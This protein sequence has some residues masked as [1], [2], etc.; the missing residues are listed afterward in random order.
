MR[1]G[2]VKA[3]P[4][5][6]HVPTQHLISVTAR[7]TLPRRATPPPP[8]TCRREGE[9]KW[10]LTS[11]Q[12]LHGSRCPAT[13]SRRRSGPSAATLG[14]RTRW[15]PAPLSCARVSGKGT[16]TTPRS[17]AIPCPHVRKSRPS[18]IGG[19]VGEGTRETLR[20]N[21]SAP[22]SRGAGEERG[23]V[24]CPRPDHTPPLFQ[25]SDLNLVGHGGAGRGTFQATGRKEDTQASRLHGLWRVAKFVSF[26][27]HARVERAA[28]GKR[29]TPHPWPRGHS[30]L[31]GGADGFS[32]APS[33][34]L[35]PPRGSHAPGESPE[36]PQ[37]RPAPSLAG[38][39][40]GGGGVCVVC[41]TASARTLRGATSAA[42]PGRGLSRSRPG[43]AR[44]DAASSTR[45][46]APLGRRRGW[47]FRSFRDLRARR[48]QGRR[49]RERRLRSR[50]SDALAVS[51]SVPLAPL[52]PRGPASAPPPTPQQF[53]V[54]PVP[55]HAELRAPWLPHQ[56][57]PPHPVTR[58][59]A[60]P[61]TRGAARSQRP[62]HAGSAL[63]C[64]NRHPHP[65]GPLS[66]PGSPASCAATAARDPP[67]S[68]LPLSCLFRSTNNFCS[69][70]GSLG[71]WRPLLP[72]PPSGYENSKQLA[73]LRADQLRL[74]PTP[75]FRSNPAAAAS[76]ISLRAG[77]GGGGDF[78]RRGCLR[79]KEPLHAPSSPP[80]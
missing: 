38:S 69:D 34:A 62:E 3:H 28:L 6:V 46:G 23:W 55:Q 65:A 47:R 58:A 1:T 52:R 75:A 32:T 15:R 76:K 66:Q 20:D 35:R 60:S 78:S 16:S 4:D 42:F 5:S 44:R 39:S 79:S 40:G 24:S 18:P 17:E 2:E 36:S 22:S 50:G 9:C 31:Q 54:P 73:D 67:P 49:L 7:N 13:P 26:P 48:K 70:A 71:P 33:P 25:A 37:R 72:A 12:T 45:N 27:S 51:A 29:E 19:G 43:A 59:P 56:H 14:T 30:C 53:L 80:K 74:P 61:R 41:T 64:E 10:R 11:S 77:L 63:G 68:R 21:C 8:P 57:P